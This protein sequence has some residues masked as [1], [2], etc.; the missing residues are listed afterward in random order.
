M[1]KIN[2]IYLLTNTLNYSNI[3]IQKR[4]DRNV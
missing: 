3:K 4:G 1:V 2:I